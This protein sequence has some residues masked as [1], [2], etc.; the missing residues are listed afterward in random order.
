MGGENSH[1]ETTPPPSLTRVQQESSKRATCC[2]RSFISTIKTVWVWWLLSCFIIMT[3]YRYA[4]GVT[5]QF[6]NTSPEPWDSSFLYD[7]SPPPSRPSW[8]FQNGPEATLCS[9]LAPLTSRSF[10]YVSTLDQTQAREAENNLWKMLFCR[11]KLNVLRR[12]S[13]AGFQN[14]ELASESQ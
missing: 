9:L 2:S 14:S 4:T 11:R 1:S 13:A 6:L 8:R 12:K 5:G 3:W 10:D 7:L